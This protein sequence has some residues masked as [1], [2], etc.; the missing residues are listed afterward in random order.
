MKIALVRH[1]ETVYNQLGKIQ[2]KSNIPL[3]D[4]GRRQCKKL[5]EKIKDKKYDICFSSPLIRAME[6][7][8][9]LVG[10]KVLINKDDRLI[11]RGMGKL[12][13]TFREKYDY[14]KFWDYKLNCGEDDIEKVQD[15]FKRCEDFLNY[16]KENYNDKSILIVT[17]DAT[18][19]TLHHILYNTD[20]NKDLFNFS[21]QN[22]CYEEI[23]I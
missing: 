6:T 3:S 10:D 8:M 7:A 21:I 22:C 18:L 19:R 15:I 4:E 9:I 14:K 17:H 11:E 23:E 1:G 20:R 16:L 12:E 2:G 5:K 13:G